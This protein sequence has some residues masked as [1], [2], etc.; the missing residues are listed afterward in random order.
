M[1]NTKKQELRGVKGFFYDLRALLKKKR[2]KNNL[3][4][5]ILFPYFFDEY[6]KQ[7]QCN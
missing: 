5:I 7:W 6:C 2:K 1:E 3:F 4:F